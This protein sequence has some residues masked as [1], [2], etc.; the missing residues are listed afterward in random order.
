[1]TLLN[2]PFGELDVPFTAQYAASDFTSGSAKY[3]A[4][5]NE[6]KRRLQG[7]WLLERFSR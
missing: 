4:F 3:N 1:M 6:A 2:H 7:R 5:V